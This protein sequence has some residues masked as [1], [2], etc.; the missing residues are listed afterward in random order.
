MSSAF[1]AQLFLAELSRLLDEGQVRLEPRNPKTTGFCSSKD[2]RKRMFLIAAEISRPTT[3]NGDHT[4][5]GLDRWA[6]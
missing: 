1:Q 4:K 6:M 3:I 5:T 2:L